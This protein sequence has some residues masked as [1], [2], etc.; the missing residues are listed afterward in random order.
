MRLNLNITRSGI[1]CLLIFSTIAFAGPKKDKDQVW[2]PSSSSKGK[3]VPWTILCW[4]VQGI[5]RLSYVEQV[6]DALRNTDGVR[7]KEVYVNSE[8]DGFIRLYYGEYFRKMNEKV[9]R[10]EVPKK[11]Q[12]DM[13]LV[14][15]LGINTDQAVFRFAR[16]VP[17][18]LPDVGNPAWSLTRA[19][20]IYTL[21]VAVFEPADDFWDYKNAAAEYCDYLRKKGY[22]A[23]YHHAPASS[24]VS[25]GVFGPEAVIESE[26]G[27]IRY[28]SEVVSLQED[29]LLK[30]NLVNGAVVRTKNASATVPFEPI[31]DASYQAATARKGDKKNLGAFVGKSFKFDLAGRDAKDGVLMTSRL[32]FIPGREEL[33]RQ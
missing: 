10:R 25:V 23:Y 17:K 8:S 1:A 6:A 3:G 11:L 29:D 13:A 2:S 14:K 15:S 7:P 18:P 33:F 31:D 32:V 20:G 28:S 16:M 4:E 30:Y 9:G 27:Q 24:I 19:P 26:K 12:D 5:N 21:Q 22:E